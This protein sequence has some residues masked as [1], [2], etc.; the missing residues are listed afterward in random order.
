M[1]KYVKRGFEFTVDSRLNVPL[2]YQNQP[3]LPAVGS[4]P[5]PF[6]CSLPAAAAAAAAAALQP[7]PSPADA[8]AG[9]RH[10]MARSARKPP[11][12]YL[13]ACGPLRPSARR[14]LLLADASTQASQ[15]GSTAEEV[16]GAADAGAGAQVAR[17]TCARGV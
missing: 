9:R 7:S 16:M 11:P 5:P 10:D 13:S 12:A 4:M 15:S 3:S 17:K 1:T 6:P 2:A 8:R 14:H